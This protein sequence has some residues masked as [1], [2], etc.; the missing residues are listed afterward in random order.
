VSKQQFSETDPR[1]QSALAELKAMIVECWPGACFSVSQ[2]E[3]P[4]GVYL[5]AIV[6]LDDPD[7]VLDLVV[8]RLLELQVNEGLPVHVVPLRTP[9]R[10]A[11]LGRKVRRPYAPATLDALLGPAV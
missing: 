11:A 5:D 7:K 1:I 4:A 2:S 6:D 10:A 8:N 9:E 3:D